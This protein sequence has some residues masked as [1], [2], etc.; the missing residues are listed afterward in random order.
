MAYDQQETGFQKFLKSKA[1]PYV[2]MVLA[3]LL[4]FLCLYTGFLSILGIC[5]P[6]IVGIL[7]YA[8]PK[9]MG[10]D[11]KKLLVFGPACWARWWACCW[12]PSISI[13]CCA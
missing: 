11:W 2:G 3:F 9:V 10:A 5:G 8:I 12:R 1:A 4:G 7:M 6:F 13:C